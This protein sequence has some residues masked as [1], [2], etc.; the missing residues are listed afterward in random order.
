M[1]QRRVP[2]EDKG[3]YRVSK[4]EYSTRIT[5]VS[6]VVSIR[7]LGKTVDTMKYQ[8]N[9]RPVEDGAYDELGLTLKAMTRYLKQ[10]VM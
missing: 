1:G 9:G 2:Q 7:Y 5:G 8:V 6:A 4:G 10:E 3:L